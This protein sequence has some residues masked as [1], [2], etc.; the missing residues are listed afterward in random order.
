MEIYRQPQWMSYL[1]FTLV[2]S[3]QYL[4]L[5]QIRCYVAIELEWLLV[6]VFSFDHQSKLFRKLY[7][8]WEVEPQK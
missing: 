4:K 7:L 3:C 8:G 1:P 5:G 2:T 6:W